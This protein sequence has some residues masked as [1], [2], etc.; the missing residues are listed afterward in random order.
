VFAKFGRDF[1]LEIIEKRQARKQAEFLADLL[2]KFAHAK[3]VQEE[4]RMEILFYV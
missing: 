1:L 4:I 2:Q 3:R